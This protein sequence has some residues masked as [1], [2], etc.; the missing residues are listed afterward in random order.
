MNI[1]DEITAANDRI[2]SHILHTPLLHSPYLSSLADGKVYLKMESEQYTGSFKARGSLNKLIWLKEQE[3]KFFPIT[4][5][6]GNHGLGFARA[7]KLLG[8]NGRIYLP[9]TAVQSKIER[10]K[11][12]G[13]EIAFYGKDPYKT[14]LYAK[15]LAEE[16]DNWVYISPY[17]D[18]QIIGGQGTIGIEILEDLETPDIIFA[19]VGGGGLISGIASY[20]NQHSPE[21]R[22]IGCQPRNSPEMSV[23]VKAGTYREIESK[24]TL[25]DGSAGGFERDSIT[26]DLC[27][28]LVEQFILVSEEEIAESIRLMISKHSKLVEGAAAVAVASFLKEIEQFKGG[29]SVII[30]C[31]ANISYKQLKDIL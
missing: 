14:E 6:T 27:K 4:A 9:E 19:T 15:N 10:I 5:S 31:G 16:H 28:E 17:N 13:A 22:V 21:T 11:E 26:F 7:L 30:I 25:S 8:I 29:T 1:Y 12:Y 24:P 18:P 3:T 2:R 23:S 20:V